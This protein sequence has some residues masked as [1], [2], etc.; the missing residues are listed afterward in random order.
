MNIRNG[1]SI[2][3]SLAV[4]VA[5]CSQS[6]RSEQEPSTTAWISGATPDLILNAAK[7][8]VRGR[9]RIAQIDRNTYTL[10]TEPYQYTSSEDTGRLSD[11]L[12]PGNHTF[13]RIVRIQASPVDDLTRVD[14]RVAVERRDTS[15][16]RAFAV[17]QQRSDLPVSTPIDEASP[18]RERSEFWTFVRRDRPEEQQLISDIRALLTPSV[19]KAMQ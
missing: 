9:Y 6:F 11:Q 5:G 7:T 12:S 8:A 3:V 19:G 16:A 2:G 15:A 17:Q 18:S 13:R 10:V 4:F 1:L 14:V